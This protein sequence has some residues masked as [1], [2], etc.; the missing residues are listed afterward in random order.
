[1]LDECFLRIRNLNRDDRAAAH[2]RTDR[3]GSVTHKCQAFP[4]IIQSN[5]RF[6]V[7]IFDKAGTVIFNY[8]LAAMFRLA[9]LDVDV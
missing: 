4:N 7:T 8:D 5:M 1:M 2:K 9:G 6:L 3:Q